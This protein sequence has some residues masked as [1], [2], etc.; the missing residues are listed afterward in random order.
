[1]LLKQKL[2]QWNQQL[3]LSVAYVLSLS[4]QTMCCGYLVWHA[5]HVHI[6]APLYILK[7]KHGQWLSQTFGGCVSSQNMR[8][9]HHSPA[10]MFVVLA[11]GPQSED[12]AGI[13][14]K[15]RRES[16]GGKWCTL[17]WW[18]VFGADYSVV[19]LVF[20]ADL[21]L[22]WKSGLG[23]KEK[24]QML[25]LLKAFFKISLQFPSVVP[26]KLCWSMWFSN[27]SKD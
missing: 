27:S 11:A 26:V 3:S 12:M 20:L 8:D 22:E 25:N 19:K 24:R 7:M 16:R 23:L 9:P 21:A 2:L 14:E 5:A 18:K 10:G 13:S 4:V 1:M 15:E 17:L 6:P